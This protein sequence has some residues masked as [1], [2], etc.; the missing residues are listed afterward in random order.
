MPRLDNQ[1]PS[2]DR[3]LLAATA[4][5]AESLLERHLSKTKEWFPHELVP[6]SMGRDFQP[7]EAWD[8]E[9]FPLPDAVRSALYL[10]LLTEDNLPYY[11]HSI[12]WLFGEDSV[13]GVWNR[14]WTAEEHRHSIVIRDWLTVTRALDPVELERARMAQVSAG[15]APEGKLVNTCEGV[16][17]VTLQELAT[18][19]SH[20]NTGRLL[21]DTGQEVMAKVAAD[22]NFHFL[23]YRDLATAMLAVDPSRMVMA[24]ETQVKNF[25]MPGAGIP[26]FAR[27]A[28]ATASAGIYDFNIHYEQI[29][30]PVILR[31]WRLESL[32][33]L[34]AEAEQARERTMAHMQRIERVSRRVAERRDRRMASAS[35]G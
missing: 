5:V 34:N 11:F 25:Q 13:W 32:T 31:H 29:L 3:E 8:P 21:D 7:G 33:G 20:R 24:F 2:A 28:A 15:Y 35:V 10:N 19:I 6:W 30:A 12:S 14:R 27:H 9:E 17:Y 26:D 4:Q 18:R 1:P 22:E 16:T 23:F